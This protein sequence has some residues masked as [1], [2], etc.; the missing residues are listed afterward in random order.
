M[1]EEVS[2]YLGGPIKY[3]DDERGWRQLAE[4]TTECS[5][6]NTKVELNWLNPLDKYNCKE[7]S[8]HILP[9]GKEGTGDDTIVNDWEIVDE[10]LKLIGR[11]DIMFIGEWN[12]DVRSVGTPMEIMYAN[13]V[14]PMPIIAFGESP[15]DFLSPWFRHH[16]DHYYTDFGKALAAVCDMAVGVVEDGPVA[17]VRSPEPSGVHKPQAWE[18]DVNHEF[19]VD[20]T[21]TT[22]GE[23]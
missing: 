10:D 16:V 3:A 18:D 1:R 19:A 11:A 13:Y 4:K 21:S 14:Q 17:L 22:G 9:D 7:D 2:V 12:V 5:N 8:I 20:G 6:G 23:R 15:F